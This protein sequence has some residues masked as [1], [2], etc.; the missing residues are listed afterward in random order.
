MKE[1][2]QAIVRGFTES[3]RRVNELDDRITALE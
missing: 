2:T 1:L 3:A